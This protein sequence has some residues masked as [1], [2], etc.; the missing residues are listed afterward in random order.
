MEIVTETQAE[1]EA[2]PGVMQGDRWSCRH[3][4]PA[5]ERRGGQ[6]LERERKRAPVREMQREG[7]SSHCRGEPQ[8]HRD[9]EIEAERCCRVTHAG[10]D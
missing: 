8:K 6:S 5:S 4:D 2:A 1:T 3:A 9:A 7:K 10:A